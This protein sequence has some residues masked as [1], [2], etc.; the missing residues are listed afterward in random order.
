MPAPCAPRG[1]HPCRNVGNFD[2]VEMACGMGYLSDY[3]AANF[4]GGRLHKDVPAD[5]LPVHRAAAAAAAAACS[6]TRS[7]GGSSRRRS[8]ALLLTLRLHAAGLPEAVFQGGAACGAC[9]RIWCVDSV[10]LD[11][12][13]ELAGC[14]CAASAGVGPPAASA[15]A[16]ACPPACAALHPSSQQSLPP[17]LCAWHAQSA[18][19][20]SW[21]RT[22][23]WTARAR[24]CW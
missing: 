21:W 19:L 9:I 24:T 14:P 5:A 20:P 18:M 23:A 17:V 4:A 6:G 12:L 8:S 2:G 11:P 3:F 16:G 13:S 7:G 10:C 1:L 15:G 22:A